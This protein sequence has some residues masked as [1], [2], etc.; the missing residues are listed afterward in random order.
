VLTE[1]PFCLNLAEAAEIADAVQTNGIILM[2]AHNQLFFPSVLQAKQMLL[3]GDLGKLYAIHSFDCSGRR[4]SLNLDK[5]TWDAG[6]RS[7]MS[8][9]RSDPVQM[10][11]G[12]LIDT[13]YHPT[14]RL[15]FLA[16]QV[17]VQTTATTG[18]FRLNMEA[19]DTA[20]VLLKFG[21]GMLGHIF[22][23]WA[24]GVPGGRPLLFSIM[25]EAG[26]LWGEIDKLYYQP[27][28]FQSPAMVEYPGWNYGRS[29]HAEIEHFVNCIEQEIEPIHS[30]AEATDTLRV[31]LASYQAIEERNI[32]TLT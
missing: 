1:K 30:V 17:P 2:A 23:S 31:I 10:G 7:G 14:Y 16:G 28:G 21:D 22:T 12:E 29:F 13:G 5:S 25:G 18:V 15:L 32:A 26:Q 11:G 6:A 24:M 9:W 20:Q 8:G 19:E 4:P 27:V 3:H